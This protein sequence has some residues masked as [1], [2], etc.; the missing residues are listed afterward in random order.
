M[1]ILN[2]HFDQSLDLVPFGH[3]CAFQCAA[4]YFLTD[5][6]RETV[7]GY[8]CPR[9][10]QKDKTMLNRYI[11]LAFEQVAEVI[12]IDQTELCTYVKLIYHDLTIEVSVLDRWYGV[13]KRLYASTIAS[14]LI[15]ERPINA[16][17]GN[18]YYID[19][20]FKNYIKENPIC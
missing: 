2:P 12:D 3:E 13:A 7:E 17:Q 19:S 5:E 8:M 15:V 1:S 18:I 4:T 11:R 16:P 10:F 20:P 9:G 6:D 14:E